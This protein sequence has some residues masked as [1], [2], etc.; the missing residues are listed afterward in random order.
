M[1]DV[2]KVW[3]ANTKTFLLVAAADV[4][5]R[6]VKTIFCKQCDFE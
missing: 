1:A 3:V 4:L 5:I 6:V 2:N